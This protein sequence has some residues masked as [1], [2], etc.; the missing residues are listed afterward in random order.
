MVYVC[1]FYLLFRC[2][3]VGGGCTRYAQVKVVQVEIIHFYVSIITV[4]YTTIKLSS[5]ILSGVILSGIEQLKPHGLPHLRKVAK[6][7][8]IL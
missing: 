7:C 3:S 2:N 4:I 8:T 6:M 5:V 1:V